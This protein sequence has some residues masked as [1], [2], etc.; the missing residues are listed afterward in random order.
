MTTAPQGE[1]EVIQK[2]V[3]CAA[4]YYQDEKGQD[5]CKTCPDG[6]SSVEGA[7]ECFDCD[8]VNFRP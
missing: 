3:P 7:V 5:T 1:K 8:Q 2:C 6:K 4:G